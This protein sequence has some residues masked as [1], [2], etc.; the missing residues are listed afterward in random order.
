MAKGKFSATTASTIAVATNKY[1]DKLVIQ[2]T[3][4]TAVAI[5]IG[6]AA[7]LD[8]GILLSKAGDIVILRGA[9]ARANIYAIG[10]G[11]T[12]TFQDGDIEVHPAS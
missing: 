6:E 8:E 7:V 9:A 12:L 2:K 3:N 4:A 11:G 5:G 10:N 1:R